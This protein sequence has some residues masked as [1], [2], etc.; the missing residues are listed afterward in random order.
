MRLFSF[1][2]RGR[3]PTFTPTS[4]DDT[5]NGTAG[6]S[7]TVD[8][9]SYRNATT[10][11][12]L[13]ATTATGNLGHAA[14]D[15]LTGIENLWGSNYDDTNWGDDTVGQVYGF[16]GNDILAGRGGNDVFYVE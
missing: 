9:A 7:D 14:G 3:M 12:R 10:G 2:T 13:D 6:A 1:G 16:D 4:G 8:V 15:V 11:I 5:F